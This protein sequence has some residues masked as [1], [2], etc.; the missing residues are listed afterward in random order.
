MGNHEKALHM[1][2][3]A[4]ETVTQENKNR[5]FVLEDFLDRLAGPEGTTMKTEQRALLISLAAGYYNKTVELEF[6]NNAQGFNK[7]YMIMAI[8]S[9]RCAME[10]CK[11]IP[12]ELKLP[13]VDEIV[14]M[15]EKMQFKQS[16]I[17]GV[18]SRGSSR[19]SNNRVFSPPVYNQIKDANISE[20]QKYFETSPKSLDGGSKM[21]ASNRFWSPKKDMNA[22]QK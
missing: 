8:D 18:S 6:L 16:S 11:K 5:Y 3:K 20:L 14:K 21:T 12:K 15:N 13:L 4:I 1:A 10:C 2:Q 9:I 7:E 19:R 17:M 22:T